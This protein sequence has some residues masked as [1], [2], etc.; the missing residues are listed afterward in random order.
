M[1][2][3]KTFEVRRDD[4][5]FQI[6]DILRL[7]EYIADENK[8]TTRYI[9]AEVTY[10]LY[11][12]QFGIETGYVV[13]GLKILHISFSG[14]SSENI[15]KLTEEQEEIPSKP[16]TLED[17]VSRLAHKI[18]T[19][20]TEVFSAGH[21]TIGKKEED[22]FFRT[23]LKGTMDKLCEKVG[24]DPVRAPWTKRPVKKQQEKTKNCLGC[25]YQSLRNF[26]V[27]CG[28]CIDHLNYL[29]KNKENS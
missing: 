29:P 15:N 20:W 4:R 8:Y 24:I 6:G 11:G 16:I 10:I 7:K 13:M 22:S 12:G 27:D 28:W 19:L 26:P 21:G 23:T 9:D 18:D 17:K 14:L 2:G 1:S 25:F 5:G 3:E